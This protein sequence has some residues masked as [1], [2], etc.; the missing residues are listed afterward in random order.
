MFFI[1]F[2]TCYGVTLYR[3]N[4][5]V[6][7]NTWAVPANTEGSYIVEVAGRVTINS[8]ITIYDKQKVVLVGNGTINISTAVNTLFDIQSGGRLI[9][10]GPTLKGRNGASNAL[11][12][13]NGGMLLLRDGKITDHNNTNNA[14]ES[15]GGGVGIH[16]GT[17]YMYGGE[18]SGNAGAGGGVYIRSGTF[19]MS[20]GT[21]RGNISRG[22]GG[23]VHSTGVTF[24]MN[25]GT[26]SGN[27]TAHYGGGVYSGGGGTF[28]LNIPAAVGNITG[29]TD[30]GTATPDVY[31]AGGG[32][33]DGT[34]G[35][36]AGW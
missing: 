25:G 31:R 9:I 27:S 8:P 35:R 30:N 16:S 32:T 1:S 12:Q 29:N 34:A 23:G 22:D 26:I 19:T 20:G 13:V 15:A 33:I 2:S 5:S 24:I 3:M 7:N 28:T 17:F 36:T 21:I 11:I 4:P 18:I 14:G 10:Q 6:G